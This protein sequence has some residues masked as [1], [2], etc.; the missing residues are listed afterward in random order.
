MGL[1]GGDF[2]V[3]SRCISVVLAVWSS[4]P[5]FADLMPSSD[6]GA[7]W[8]P[9]RRRRRRCE[10]ITT[11]SPPFVVA[12]MQNWPCFVATD[13]VVRDGSFVRD[14]AVIRPRSPS[15]GRLNVLVAH[16]I[17]VPR[18]QVEDLAVA[19]LGA[20]RAGSFRLR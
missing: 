9:L 1:L 10:L 19:S 14:L 5:F 15:G 4:W 13:L 12:L 16:R 17:S 6:L 18:F 8:G 3:A 7:T 20:N 2:A 11:R